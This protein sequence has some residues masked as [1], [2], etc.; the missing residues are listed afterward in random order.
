MNP[1]LSIFAEVRTRNEEKEAKHGAGPRETGK[2]KKKNGPEE[3]EEKNK[4]NVIGPL[5]Q[6]TKSKP[7]LSGP[8][9][10]PNW[11]LTV[12]R[13]TCP[14][15]KDTHSRPKPNFIAARRLPDTRHIQMY[16]PI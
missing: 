5:T 14:I 15:A 1:S 8:N 13:P 4:E 12:H 10:N 6:L 11:A 3:K 9:S 16:S 7:K 2:R